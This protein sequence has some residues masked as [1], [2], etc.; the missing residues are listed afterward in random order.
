MAKRVSVTHLVQWFAL[1]A[2]GK[3][4]HHLFGEGVPVLR[5]TDGRDRHNLLLPVYIEVLCSRRCIKGSRDP[6]GAQFEP[7]RLE[8]HR[9][10][11]VA[12][13]FITAF[14]FGFPDKSDIGRGTFNNS[15]APANTGKD[16][17]VVGRY[18]LNPAGFHRLVQLGDKFPESIEFL[19]LYPCPQKLAPGVA[20]GNSL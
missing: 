2:A 7:D 10:A 5:V 1:P 3:A 4:A 15:I 12:E 14:F 6:A 11:N 9:L 13:L 17:P 16:P 19:S 8:H 18:Q 20:S